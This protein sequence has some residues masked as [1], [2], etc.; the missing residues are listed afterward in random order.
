MPVWRLVGG[1][2]V[3]VARLDAPLLADTHAVAPHLAASGAA[4]R[5]AVR[6]LLSYALARGGVPS[7]AEDLR[8]RPNGSPYL[9]S[10]PDIGVSLSHDGGWVAVALHPAAAVGV[11]VQTPRPVSERMLRRC[12]RPAV[13]AELGCMHPADRDAAFARIWS[14]QEACVKATGAG[15]RGRPWE[16]PVGPSGRRGRWEQVRW[17]RLSLTSD[18]PPPGG[19][20]VCVAVVDRTMGDTGP[21]HQKAPR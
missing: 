6:A 20:A 8:A 15:L 13:L 17:Y 1:A 16:I 4:E 10:R 5:R 2:S 7:A 18:E 21:R 9:V 12:C 3:A 19:V 14:V 11:D